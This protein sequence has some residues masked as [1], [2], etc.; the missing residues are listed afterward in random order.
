MKTLIVLQPEDDWITESWLRDQT[1]TRVVSPGEYLSESIEGLPRSIRVCNLCRS[2]RYQSTG[3][4]VSLL[5]EAR[6]H[7]AY[8]DVLTIGDISLSRSVRMVPPSLEAIIEKALSPLT[9]DE[10]VLSVYFGENLAKRYQR[11]ARAIQSQFNAPLIRCCFKRRKRWR[12]QSVSAISIADVP[13]NHREFVAEVARQ[14]LGR[15]SVSRPS[16]RPPRYDLAILQNP[17]EGDLAPSCPKALRQFVRVAEDESVRAE[18]ITAADAGRLFEFDAL[19]IRETTSV[20]HHTYRMARRAEAAGMVVIDDPTSILRCSNKV[21]LAELL[22]R[23]KIPAPPTMILQRGDE[24]FE[25]QLPEL[26]CVI[27]RP[28]SAFSQGVAKAENESQLRL[29]LENYFEDSELLI[30]QPFLPTD[31]DWRIGLIDGEP[32]FACK[33]HMARGH[34]QIAKH[35]ADSK[36]PRFG[37]CET[38]PVESAPKKCVALAKKASELIGRGFYGVDIKQSGDQFYVI[39]VNDN[40]NLDAGVED[41]VLGREVYRRIIRTLIRRIENSRRLEP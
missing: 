23:A 24:Q 34:W 15:G 2:Y 4:Y 38:M 33:Y 35:S 39:E 11:L 36:T 27:K 17:D 21:Y 29:L 31:F 28:D 30:A 37:K 8:P 6:G 10:F 32:L 7:R 16:Y 20:N 12:I 14:H 3:Y 5:A 25:R 1:E 19:L 18:L 9:S 41:K 40:P 13:E 22:S 26:P